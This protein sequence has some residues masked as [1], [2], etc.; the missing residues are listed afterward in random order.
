[1]KGYYQAIFRMEKAG[2]WVMDFGGLKEFKAW[3]E[4]MFDH[5]SRVKIGGATRKK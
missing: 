1:M 4:D 2:N 5:P 3:L